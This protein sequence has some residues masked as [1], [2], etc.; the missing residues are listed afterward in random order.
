MYGHQIQ[1]VVIFRSIDVWISALRTEQCLNGNKLCRA[2]CDTQHMP[3]RGLRHR[4]P[5]PIDAS[6]YIVGSIYSRQPPA[7]GLAE[8]MHIHHA[9]PWKQR[10]GFH[11]GAPWFH[12]CRAPTPRD[13]EARACY[14]V[15]GGG[16]I[17][18]WTT[19]V[20]VIVRCHGFASVPIR[21]YLG[22]SYDRSYDRW[23]SPS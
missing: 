7:P 11:Q 23:Y 2:A 20:R 10:L 6:C 16:G 15:G 14:E 13:A 5:I 4:S 19:G 22:I 9:S 12:H 3:A 1:A 17:S 18:A 8:R 21:R